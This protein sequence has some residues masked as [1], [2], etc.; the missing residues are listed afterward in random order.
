MIAP[1]KLPY[2]LFLVM[3]SRQQAPISQPSGMRLIIIPRVSPLFLLKRATPGRQ[4]DGRF[5][6]PLQQDIQLTIQQRFQPGWLSHGRL[7]TKSE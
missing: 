1:T 4:R 3:P 2:G 5:A 6:D 7:R